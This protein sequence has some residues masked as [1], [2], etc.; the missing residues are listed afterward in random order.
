MMKR[1][2]Q[3]FSLIELMIV[4]AIVGILAAV[5]YPSYVDHIVRGKRAAAASF[6]MSLANRQEQYMLDARSYATSATA[7]GF[8]ASS[9]P[10]EVSENY[11]ITV[12][13]DNSASPPTYTITAAPKGAQ[14]SR[15]TKC[16]SLTINQA[17]T[18]GIA[19]G[20]GTASSCWG[21]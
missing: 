13:A 7:L 20:S 17:G 8:S 4:V 1:A 18:K 16:A 5:A 6:I 10:K 19:G 2:S 14:A 11:D 21:N 3:G 9:V 15:D 12:V